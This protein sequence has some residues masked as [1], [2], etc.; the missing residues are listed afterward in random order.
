M[1]IP[2]QLDVV[3]VGRTAST[4]VLRAIR[5]SRAHHSHQ[6]ST[7]A[8]VRRAIMDNQICRTELHLSDLLGIVH[9]GRS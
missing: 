4:I 3:W 8:T 9:F 7:L 5:D 1:F 2:V 6:V